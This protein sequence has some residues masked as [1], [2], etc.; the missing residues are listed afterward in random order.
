[1][2][3][4]TNAT[5]RMR[6]DSSGNLLV[7]TTSASARLYVADS[8]STNA[9]YAFGVSSAVSG[10]G[11]L[12]VR[13]D[14]YVQMEYTYNALTSAAGAN[15]VIGS[16][17]YIYRSTS[18]LKYKTDV[19]DLESI[20]INK[21]RPVRYKSKCT[22]DDA[23]KDF[24]GVIADEVDAAGIKELVTYGETGE[25]EGFQYERLTVVLLKSI[26]EQQAMIQE[27]KA[28]IDLLKGVK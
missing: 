4:A 19:R 28:E 22:D 13:S 26:Q 12:F 27:L 25:V 15:M 6:I 7:G 16:G 5:E 8:R 1:M 23:N 20:D 10:N 24:F 18:A 2:A 3:F 9:S 11:L 21:F 17:G 14:G